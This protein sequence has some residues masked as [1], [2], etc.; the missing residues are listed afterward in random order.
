MP[1]KKDVPF[2]DNQCS[3]MDTHPQ[4][5]KDGIVLNVVL[6]PLKQDQ[7]SQ[8]TSG[9]DCLSVGFYQTPH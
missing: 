6:L 9:E 7:I 3:G 5:N 8:R 2:A 1:N 4:V